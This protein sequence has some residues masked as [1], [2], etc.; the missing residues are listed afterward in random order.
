MIRRSYVFLF[1]LL[2]A[3]GSSSSSS[4][5]PPSSSSAGSDG[6]APAAGDGGS[7]A[8]GDACEGANDDGILG[9]WSNEQAAGGDGPNGIVMVKVTYRFCGTPTGGTYRY[10]ED[11]VGTPYAGC[12]RVADVRGTFTLE[13]KK[14]LLSLK[15]GYQA[16]EDCP[17]PSLDSRNDVAPGLDYTT[18]YEVE[19]LGDSLTMVH[20]SQSGDSSP[21]VYTREN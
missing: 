4:S 14:L 15:S 2:A 21:Y 11:G 7:N 17:D 8:D 5:S 1:A 19:V 12:R 18:E 13:G 10:E 3:C 6:G 9:S 16:T 20:K